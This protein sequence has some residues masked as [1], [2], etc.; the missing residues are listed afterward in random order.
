MNNAIYARVSTNRQDTGLEAQISACKEKARN[1]MTF[2]DTISGAK[3][4]RPGLDQL[5]DK[6]KAGEISRVYIFSLSRL[7]RSLIHLVT[8]IKEFQAHNVIL[9]SLTEGFD[10]STPAGRFAFNVLASAAEYEREII[11]ERVKNGLENAKAKGHAPGRPEIKVDIKR[12]RELSKQHT[13]REIA[14]KIGVSASTVS[15]RLRKRNLTTR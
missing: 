5:M 1:A 2:T 14:K 15:R 13:C 7:G 10:L 9:L 3:D 11:C 6:I 8:L 12:L 4:S